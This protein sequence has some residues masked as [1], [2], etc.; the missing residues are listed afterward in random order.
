M[1]TGL[2]IELDRADVA[3]VGGGIVGITTAYFLAE[4]GYDVVVL[5][6]EHLAWGASGRNAGIQWMHTRTAGIALDLARLGQRIMHDLTSELGRSFELRRN[7]G[8]FYFTSN[9]Q[10]RVFE[11]F[12]EVR[13]AEGVHIEVL[14]QAQARELCPMLPQDAIG[15]TYCPEDG[16]LRSAWFVQQLGHACRRRGV[17]IHE[18]TP[19]LGPLHGNAG[20]EGVQTLDGVVRAD[21]VVYATG[22]WSSQLDRE[23]LRV[24]I[25]PE[26]LGVMLTEPI[27]GDMHVGMLSPLAAKQYEMIRNLPSFRIEDFS[28]DLERPDLG[29]VYFE[30]ALQREDGRLLVGNPEDFEGGLSLRTPLQS[31]KMMVDGLLWRWPHLAKVE[32]EDLWSCQIPITPDA[33]PIIDAIDE[34]P[35]LFLAAGHVFGNLAGPST[36]LVTAELVAGEPTSLPLAELAYDRASLQSTPDEGFMAHW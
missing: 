3:I 24:P 22:A 13:R 34:I 27:P 8:I 29:Y 35:G 11:E 4:K 15:A 19:V 5:E 16:Q 20:V 26:R 33:L 31:L 1:R 9:A 10:R 25:I 18:R 6:R 36:G 21:R 17:R 28:A 30:L 32:V 23:G 2:E 7:G 14:D 12:A